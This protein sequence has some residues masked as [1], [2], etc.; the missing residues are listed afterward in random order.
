MAKI[1]EVVPD[2][3][4]IKAI[5]QIQENWSSYNQPKHPEEKISVWSRGLLNSLRNRFNV[6][7]TRKEPTSTD[8]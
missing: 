1:Y 7:I 5:S 2:D 8:N 4:I 6:R 3:E